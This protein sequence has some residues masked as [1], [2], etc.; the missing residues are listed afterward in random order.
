VPRGLACAL[1]NALKEVNNKD[2]IFLSHSNLGC[3]QKSSTGKLTVDYYCDDVCA[4]VK[5]VKPNRISIFEQ[6]RIR[7][8][9]KCKN[10]KLKMTALVILDWQEMHV[11][12]SLGAFSR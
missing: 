6:K 8:W 7:F 9:L 5:R 10:Q 11:L 12:F 1:G 2:S 3:L 4:D